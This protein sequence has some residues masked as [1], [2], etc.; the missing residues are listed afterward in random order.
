[1]NTFFGV[2]IIHLLPPD[3]EK[4]SKNCQ[5]G[6][7]WYKKVPRSINLVAQTIQKVPGSNKAGAFYNKMAGLSIQPGVPGVETDVKRVQA[8]SF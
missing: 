6:A 4:V 2:R 5:A 3:P 7:I 8:G 1:V